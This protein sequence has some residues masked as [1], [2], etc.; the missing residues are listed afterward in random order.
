MVSENSGATPVRQTHGVKYHEVGLQELQVL[1]EVRN[2]N[3]YSG[4][5]AG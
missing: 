5:I 3:S 1:E 2:S 4:F